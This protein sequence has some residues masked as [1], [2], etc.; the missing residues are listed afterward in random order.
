M[1]KKSITLTRFSKE[2]VTLEKVEKTNKRH[3]NFKFK[4]A[5]LLNP[6]AGRVICQHDINSEDSREKDRSELCGTLLSELT[7]V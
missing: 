6:K 7:F 3:T 1:G 2:S 4:C 5:Y